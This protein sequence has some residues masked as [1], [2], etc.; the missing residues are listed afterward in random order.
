MDDIAAGEIICRCDFRLPGLFFMALLFH[1]L[2]TGQPELHTCEGVDG[3]VDTAV[4]GIKAAQHLAVCRI[5]N[6][7]TAQN[8]NVSLP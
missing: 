6:R 8:S 3:V 5:D 2:C 1:H 7:V 4:A